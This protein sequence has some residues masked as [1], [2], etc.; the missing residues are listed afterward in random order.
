M[1][2]V[3]SVTGNWR[4]P[5]PGGKGEAAGGRAASPSVD[6][7]VSVSANASQ[8]LLYSSR[9]RTVSVNGMPAST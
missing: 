5:A 4:T 7:K 8:G 6:V 3:W 9:T 2:V 1:P